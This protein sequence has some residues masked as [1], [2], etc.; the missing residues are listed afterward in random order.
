MTTVA[1]LGDRRRLAPAAA[2]RAL[3]GGTLARALHDWYRS[4]YLDSRRPHR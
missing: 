2:A 3:A 1:A 4:G